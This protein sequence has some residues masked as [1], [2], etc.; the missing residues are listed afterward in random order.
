MRAKK[1]ANNVCDAHYEQKLATPH[2]LDV[3]KID[4]RKCPKRNTEVQNENIYCQ[5][6]RPEIIEETSLIN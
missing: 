2:T 1:L 4:S 3:I 6:A 5:K